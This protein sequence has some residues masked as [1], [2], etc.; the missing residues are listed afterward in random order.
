MSS[1]RPSWSSFKTL[2]KSY[3]GVHVKGNCLKKATPRGL[4]EFMGRSSFQWVCEVV[5]VTTF[6]GE[7][8]ENSSK[9]G[10]LNLWEE[11]PLKR[12]VNSYKLLLPPMNSVSLSW[13]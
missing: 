11:A 10:L 13:S 12:L 2:V 8:F 6:Q 9:T 1:V 7:C 3:M 5:Y 4:S